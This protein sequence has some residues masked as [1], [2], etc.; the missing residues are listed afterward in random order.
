MEF[1]Q[2]L[3]DISKQIYYPIYL[4]SGEE[5]Y[6]IDLVADYIAE[7]VLTEDEQSFNQSIVYGKD[8]D[9][10]T[11]IQLS[12]RF[13]MMSNYQVIIVKEA[14]DLKKIEE[15]HLYAENPLKST[16]LVICY[17]YKAFPKTTSFAKQVKKNGIIFDSPVIPEWKLGEWI[18]T[19]VKEKN[20]QIDAD[21]SELLAEYLGSTLHK[22]VNELQKLMYLLPEGSKITKNDVEKNIGISKEYNVFELQ[23]AFATKDSMKVQKILQS[24]ASN[25]KEHPTEATLPV[26]YNFFKKVLLLYFIQDKSNESISTTLKISPTPFFIQQYVN[27]QKKYSAQKLVQIISLLREYDLKTKGVQ[28]GADDRGDLMRELAF[29]ILH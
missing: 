8:T 21:V 15:L 19:F 14:Q 6:Y 3:E 20:Y 28:V 2:L 25:P 23:R 1:K 17:K 24:F 29:K 12:R 9:V 18:R 5:P 26:L 16:I 11:V 7:K 4:L 22:L 10:E 27:A 13:P